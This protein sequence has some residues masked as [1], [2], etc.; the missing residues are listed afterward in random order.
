MFYDDHNHLAPR[1]DYLSASAE[2]FQRAKCLGITL[3]ARCL[4]DAVDIT[5]NVHS[6][7]RILQ[8]RVF[9]LNDS[10]MAG[11]DLDKILNEGIKSCFGRRLG[12]SVIA[13]VS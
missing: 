13:D 3:V 4:I 11:V 6:L 5:V 10:A 7:A 12:T 8:V 2:P 9:I 1:F